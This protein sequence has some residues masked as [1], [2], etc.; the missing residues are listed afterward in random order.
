MFYQNLK[1]PKVEQSSRA[2]RTKNRPFF[3]T[4]FVQTLDGKVAVK[5]Q[6]YWPIGSKT[7]HNVLVELRAYA[8]CLIHGGNLARE[9]GRKTLESLKKGKFKNLR[10][11]LGKNPTLPYSIVTKNPKP[12]S[13]LTSGN[14]VVG[15]L[16]AILKDLNKKGYKHVLV[17]GGPT[18]LG[19]FL[20]ENLIDEIFLTIAPKIYGSQKDTTST[21]VEGVLFSP[22]KTR[23]LKLVSYKN[24][25]EELFLRYRVKA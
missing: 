10:K 11:K 4:N 8:D 2:P 13:H 9:F 6:G 25:N 15:N 24:I 1:F 20:K 5:K 19:S 17:E 16:H 21:L 3:Y 7:D 14:V 12:Y 22:R 18:L 23:K